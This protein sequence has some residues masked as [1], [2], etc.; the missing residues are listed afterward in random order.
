VYCSA[1][2]ILPVA[3]LV[4]L[5][6]S[7]ASM[8]DISL[9]QDNN[10]QGQEFRTRN[11]VRNLKS[12]GLNDRASSIIIDRGR[13]EVCSDADFGGRCM[14][15]DAGRYASIGA[16]GLNDQI[17]SI[18]PDSGR[19]TGRDAVVLYQDDGFK[20]E[21][22]PISINESDL[23]SRG[24][25]DRASSIVITYGRWEICSDADFRGRCETLEPGRYSSLRALG[26]NDSVSSI[27]RAGRGSGDS[28]PQVVIGR[29]GV[30]EVIFNENRCVVRYTGGQRTG[31][32]SSCSRSQLDRADDAMERH[33]R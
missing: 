1:K 10:F 28:A 11:E 13:W 8:A 3:G 33:R 27:R 14:T 5:L 2:K 12:V 25:N 15:L 23:K 32:S 7:A 9:F 18:R 26:L 24:F 4:T 17:S 21:S 6:A 29:N 19:G 30:A 22:L 20:G 16:M 31:N